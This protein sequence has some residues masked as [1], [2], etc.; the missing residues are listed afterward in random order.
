MTVLGEPRT[1]DERRTPDRRGAVD[2]GAWRARARRWWPAA[3][4]AVLGAVLFAVAHRAMP[5]D[6]LISLSF[7]RNLAEHGQW[8]LTTGIEVHTATSPLNIWLLA[9]LHLLTGGHAFL[10]AGALL[11]ITLAA[12]ALWLRDL[13]GDRVALLGTALLASSPLLGSA[14]GLE[15]Y[16]AVAVLVGL[17]RYAADG[18]WLPAGVLLGAAVLT[19][20]DLLAAAL[21][22]LL[23]LLPGA[24]RLWR[25][26]PVGLAVALPWHLFA[27]WRFGSA[28]PHTVPIKGNGR[29]WFDGSFYLWNSW[30][31]F[32]LVSFTGVTVVALATA[33]GGLAGAAWSL[34]TRRWVPV[35][36]AAGAVVHFAAL[37]LSHAPPMMYYAGPPI[38]AL[39]V[40]LVLAADTVRWG[41]IVPAGLV[42]AGVAVSV[43]HG[44]GWADGLA[45]VRQNWATNPEYEAIARDLPTDGVVYSSTEIG[46]LAFYCQDRG[47]TVVDGVLADP[48]RV[49][50]RWVAPWRAERPWTALNYRHYRPPAP[51]PARWRLEMGPAEPRPGDWPITRA[52]GVHQVARLVP[53]G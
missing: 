38:G 2:G 13:G 5:D 19:R 48:G 11:A 6:A 20:P 10:A 28:W 40:A 24:P 34:W 53:E 27:W 41:W 30:P 47:C 46:A 31:D 26:L 16:L 33:A 44:P 49:D 45:P 35:A 32:F 22:A 36:L 4:G 14:V 52:P 7:A 8:A 50:Q 29:G 15:T 21:V 43:L 23:V 18:R 51:I 3:W 37:G 25:A 9:A 42:A 17:V 12:T 39:A 1:A